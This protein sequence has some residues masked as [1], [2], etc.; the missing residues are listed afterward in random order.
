MQRRAFCFLLGESSEFALVEEF[1][2]VLFWFGPLKENEDEEDNILHRIENQLSKRAFHGP[3]TAGEAQVLLQKKPAAFYLLRFSGTIPGNYAISYNVGKRDGSI[4]TNHVR[5]SYEN[6]KFLAWG[7][8]FDSLQATLK[9][10]HQEPPTVR[11]PSD[12]YLV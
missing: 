5:F 6:G 7:K 8:V 2:R 9:F 3:I 4:E 10:F 1:S 11:V 12:T